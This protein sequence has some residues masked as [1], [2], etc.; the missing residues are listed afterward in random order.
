M[1]QNR[2]GVATLVLLA[3]VGLT[4]WRINARQKEDHAAPKVEVKLPKVDASKVDE[5]ELSAPDHPKVRLVKKGEQ[6]RMVEP[7]DAQGDQ[8]AVKAAL[9]KLA[10]L[11]VTGLAATK[12]ENHAKLEVDAAKGTHVIARAGGKP[13]IDAYIGIYRSGNTMLRLEGQTPVATVKGSIRYIFTKQPREWRDR[14]IA[15]VEAK[16]L[17]QVTFTNQNGHFDFTRDGDSWKQVLAKHDKRIDPLDDAKLKGI[18]STASSLNAVDFADKGVTAEQAGLGADAAS[19]TLRLGGDAGA[20]D[21]VYRIGSKKDQNYYAQREGVDTIYLI[22]GWVGGRL[23][24]SPDALVKKEEAKK[25]GPPGS[26]D[27]PIPVLPRSRRVVSA[28]ATP[29][30]VNAKAVPAKPATAKK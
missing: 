11:E 25:K 28:P 1:S 13:L 27:N 16:D 9:D 23:L 29:N 6:W 3:L 7:L 24:V 20:R 18:V 12:T 4:M 17:Q 21:V 10:D 8:D 26:P 22:S 30:V 5:L 14:T 15:K 19:V 2:L